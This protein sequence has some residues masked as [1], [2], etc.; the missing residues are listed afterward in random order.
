MKKFIVVVMCF[1]LL[2]GC[3]RGKDR[4]DT[5]SNGVS[6]NTNNVSVDS[7]ASQEVGES[8]SSKGIAVDFG[9]TLDKLSAPT[10]DDGNVTNGSQA[11]FE[12]GESDVPQESTTAGTV[13]INNGVVESLPD[14]VMELND[15]VAGKPEKMPDVEFKASMVDEAAPGFLSDVNNGSINVENTV[16]NHVVLNYPEVQEY[17]V[18]VDS[19]ISSIAIQGVLSDGSTVVIAVVTK[20][21]YNNEKYIEI[22]KL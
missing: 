15:T 12:T 13:I 6:T 3:G 21:T 14:Y 18:N 7:G 10:S 19:N 9:D 5:S 8:A 22:D 2:I 11:S 1:L 16:N 17:K 20:Y 4:I